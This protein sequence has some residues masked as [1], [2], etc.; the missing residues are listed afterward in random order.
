[1]PDTNDPRLVLTLDDARLVLTLDAGGTN[2]VFS[3]VRGGKEVTEPVTLPSLGDDL[4]ACLAQITAGF[5]ELHNRTGRAAVAIS[6]AFPGPADYR[7]GIIGDPANLPAFRDGVALGPMLEEHFDLPVFINND[8]DLFAYGEALA[9]LLPEINAA[10]DENGSTMRYHN[11]L[12]LTLGTGFGGGIVRDGH[13]FM[14]DNAAA[15]EVWALRSKLHR[16]CPVE[17][18]VSVRALRR[19]YAELAR[20]EFDHAPDAKML[21]AIARHDEKGHSAAAREA[22]RRFGEALGDAIANAVTLV[23]GLVVIGGGLSAAAPL[24]MPAVMTEL[25]G[26]LQSREGT[27]IPRLETRAF[28]LDDDTDR[29]SFLAHKVRDIQVPGSTR[30]VPYDPLKRIGIGVSKLGANRA[31]S[32]GAYAFALT[33]IGTRGTKKKS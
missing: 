28:N 12:G 18:D 23:D 3:A 33:A 7:N 32:L 22:F 25:N 29:R 17:E 16:D 4:T 10:L 26:H 8:G 24:F 30:T 1:M 31:V 2:F 15:G 20:L 13:L 19:V 6:L 21:A 5:Q 27:R 14:G 11:L 9:G